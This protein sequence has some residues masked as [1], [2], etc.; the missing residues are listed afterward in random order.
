M[1]MQQIAKQDF[2]YVFTF[3]ITN[4]WVS[5]NMT[6]LFCSTRNFNWIVEP[7]DF[8]FQFG[9]QSDPFDLPQSSKRIVA[10]GTFLLRMSQTIYVTLDEEVVSGAVRLY[11]AQK[12]FERWK[13]LRSSRPLV[14]W[15]NVGASHV[16]YQIMSLYTGVHCD[17]KLAARHRWAYCKRYLSLLR[18]E[19]GVSSLRKF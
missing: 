15:C 2:Q 12:Q 13:L 8:S 16:A 6:L 1:E 4:A 10:G 17:K 14:S 19:L 18:R 5:Q 3:T 11:H 9:L 7:F